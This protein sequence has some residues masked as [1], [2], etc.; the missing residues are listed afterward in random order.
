MIQLIFAG[1]SLVNCARHPPRHTQA[2]PTPW[3]CS[4]LGQV[5]LSLVKER[6]WYGKM[7]Q[8]SGQP[9]NHSIK[10]DAR[11][12]PNRRQGVGGGERQSKEEAEMNR[13]PSKSLLVQC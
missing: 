9:W 4:K 6:S 1:P 5:E 8:G 3:P 10:A 2:T 11:T 12:G 13:R 7:K